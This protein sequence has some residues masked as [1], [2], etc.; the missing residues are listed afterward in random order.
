MTYRPDPHEVAEVFEV[1]LWA[2]CSTPRNHRYESAFFKGRMRHY[3]AMPYGGT[4]SGGPRREC[5]SPSNGCSAG[6]SERG[7]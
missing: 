7:A 5:W 4:S 1:P 3:W 2:S 6:G